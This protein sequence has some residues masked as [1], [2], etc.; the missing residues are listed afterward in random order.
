[1]RPRSIR[2]AHDAQVIPVTGRVMFFV[3][4]VDASL[5]VHLRDD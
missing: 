2:F 5:A 4:I 3:V 1:L